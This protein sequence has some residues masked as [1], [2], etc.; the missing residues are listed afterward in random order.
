MCNAI[1]VERLLIKCGTY[2]TQ[3]KAIHH[4]GWLRV[5]P[6]QPQSRH[7]LNENVQL[8]SVSTHLALGLAASLC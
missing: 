2:T 8:L 7:C 6:L 5:V 4:L 3:K 1:L